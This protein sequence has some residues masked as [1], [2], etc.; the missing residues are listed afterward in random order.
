MVRTLP[1]S[2]EYADQERTSTDTST[3]ERMIKDKL[4]VSDVK[5]SKTIWLGKC[6]DNTPR[7]VL[8]VFDYEKTKCTMFLYWEKI[9][10]LFKRCPNKERK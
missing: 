9:I 6:R 10:P 7:S 5:I 8:F 3:V 1:K 2:V 4:S